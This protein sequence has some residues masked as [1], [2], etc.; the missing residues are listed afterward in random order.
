MNTAQE[1]GKHKRPDHIR[2]GRREYE[3]MEQLQEW[4]NQ[5]GCPVEA[6]KAIYPVIFDQA[7]Q[8]QLK[9]KGPKKSE[10]II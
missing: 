1:I 6:I 9:G 5:V 2:D 7:I 8:L 3:V 10:K 4:A